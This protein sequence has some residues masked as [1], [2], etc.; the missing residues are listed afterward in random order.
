[1]N[2]AMEKFQVVFQNAETQ[3]FRGRKKIK[4]L[5]VAPGSKAD[6]CPHLRGA[7]REGTNSHSVRTVG[8][9]VSL[10]DRWVPVKWK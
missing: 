7:G 2:N 8:K 6:L 1:M 10:G 4:G 3:V 9:L 5:A